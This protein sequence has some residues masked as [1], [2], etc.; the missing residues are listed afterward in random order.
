MGKR[1]IIQLGSYVGPSATFL[2][3]DDATTKPLI[4]SNSI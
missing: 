4:T 2:F 1:L 3:N